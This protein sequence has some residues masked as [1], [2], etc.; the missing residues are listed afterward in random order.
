MASIIIGKASVASPHPIYFEYYD[1][2][3]YQK[4]TASEAISY[5]RYCLST[6]E[7]LIVKVTVDGTPA[8]TTIEKSVDTWANRATATYTPIM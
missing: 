2:C 4:E 1:K 6:A 7:Q 5:Y 3:F 8:V